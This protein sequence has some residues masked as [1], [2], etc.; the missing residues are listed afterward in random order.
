[1]KAALARCHI[2]ARSSLVCRKKKESKFATL[3]INLSP[4]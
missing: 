2:M 4:E 1:M 3:L